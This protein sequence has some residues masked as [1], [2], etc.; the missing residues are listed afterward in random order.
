LLATDRRDLDLALSLARE[1]SRMRPEAATLDTLGLVHLE[2]GECE[3]AVDA[4]ERAVAKPDGPPTA[5]YHLAIALRESGNAIRARAMLE[6]ALEAGDFP[7][8][9][10]ARRQLAELDAR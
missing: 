5:Y 8:A 3:A 9:E 1:A 4:L 10:A 2:R 6:R 7:E